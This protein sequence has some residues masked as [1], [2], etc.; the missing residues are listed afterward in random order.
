MMAARP[1]KKCN[2]V[3]LPRA[4]NGKFCS[5]Q[6]KI[7]YFS[8]GE[9]RAAKH[10]R[11]YADPKKREKHL[12]N[13]RRW[14]A[15]N[16][17]KRIRYAVP[18]VKKFRQ[19][20][21]LLALIARLDDLEKSIAMIAAANPLAALQAE[22]HGMTTEELRNEFRSGLRLSID[23]LTRLAL[24]LTELE[25]RG[26]KIQGV[27]IGLLSLLRSIAK[28][29]LLAET[30]VAFASKPTVMRRVG[31]MPVD[32]Q[33]R[34]V[35]DEEECKRLMEPQPQRKNKKQQRPHADTSRVHIEEGNYLFS[36]KVATPKDLA[37]LIAE[38]ILANPDPAAV[39]AALMQEREIKRLIHKTKQA[40]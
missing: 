2:K 11:E 29:Q 23:H 34:I 18:Y 12:A 31:K 10:Q 14:Y 9:Y 30:V 22:I 16:R 36:A 3:F 38:M 25:S 26:E 39:W 7:H 19:T 17:E 37:A 6:C 35:D 13:Y 20:N 40:C 27:N 5:E 21:R 33:R 4:P 32:E 15:F 8:R 28:G 1:C 24:I